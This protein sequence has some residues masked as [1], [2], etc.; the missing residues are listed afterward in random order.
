MNTSARTRRPLREFL[1]ASLAA[2]RADVVQALADLCPQCCE[3][4][5]DW[6]HRALGALSMLGHWSVVEEG[7]ALEEALRG[8]PNLGLLHE[9][10]QFLEHFAQT[11]DDID[12]KSGSFDAARAVQYRA[13][14]ATAPASPVILSGTWLIADP[15]ISRTWK[16]PVGRASRTCGRRSA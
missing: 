3:R 2:L 13:S 5:A 9:M 10:L 1:R 11:V 16:L 7:N 15:L 14:S 8:T 12:R 6:L 4:Y